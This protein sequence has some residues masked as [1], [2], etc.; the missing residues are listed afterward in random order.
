MVALMVTTD[1]WDMPRSC[2]PQW[3]GVRLKHQSGGAGEGQCLNSHRDPHE[4]I[5]CD[6]HV[7]PFSGHLVME[8]NP[9][10]AAVHIAYA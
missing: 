5:W 10:L 9:V 7:L 1:I 4:H 6:L 2:T 3:V 8:R